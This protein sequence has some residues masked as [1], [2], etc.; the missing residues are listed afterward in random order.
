MELSQFWA[1]FYPLLKLKASPCLLGQPKVLQRCSGAGHTDGGDGGVTFPFKLWSCRGE[2]ACPDPAP[3]LPRV[4]PAI[5][6]RQ[7][8]T[9][10]MR[11]ARRQRAPTYCFPS[12][13]QII[14]TP[15][16]SWLVPSN[17]DLGT[18]AALNSWA[19]HHLPASL[20]LQRSSSGSDHLLSHQINLCS[21]MTVWDSVWRFKCLFSPF[22]WDL[23]LYP[24]SLFHLQ[25]L[26][27]SSG[28]FLG[29]FGWTWPCL[30]A[31]LWFLSERVQQRWGICS[32][33]QFF[34]PPKKHPL[35]LRNL[36]EF[37]GQ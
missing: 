20:P 26:L 11:K 34:F 31:G 13:F 5:L 25:L 16:T 22:S 10:A 18:A 24:H 1:F 2:K 32:L 30:R 21:L 15:V 23:L 7:Q 8:L 35:I 36:P 17:E 3:E 9:K 19:R 14:V 37:L 33:V 4:Q 12:S 29:K 6:G 27:Y 28:R